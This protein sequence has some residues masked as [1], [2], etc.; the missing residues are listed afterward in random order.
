M[1]RKSRHSDVKIT[2]LA[3]GKHPAWPDFIDDGAQ[4]GAAVVA[5]RDALWTRGLQR[6][7]QLGAFNTLAE[8]SRVRFSHDALIVTSDGT[9]VAR[10]WPGVDARGASGWPMIAV[11]HAEPVDPSWLCEVAPSR[12][13]AVQEMSGQ[14]RNRQLV[15]LSL[16]EAARQLEDTLA[17]V[18]GVPRASVSDGALLAQADAVKIAAGLEAAREQLT[19]DAR[20]EVG[21]VLRLPRV[22]SPAAPLENARVWAAALRSQ[23][24]AGLALVALE[25][26]ESD[27]VD[28]I[29]GHGKS[30]RWGAVRDASVKDSLAGRSAP[31]DASLAHVKQLK[32]TLG[33]RTR[34]AGTAPETMKPSRR[35]VAL[36]TA[37]GAL[38]ATTIVAAVLMRNTTPGGSQ[39]AGVWADARPGAKARVS[40]TAG[41]SREQAAET[42][43]AAMVEHALAAAEREGAA[44]GAT[45]P[46]DVARRARDVMARGA[47]DE[48]EAREALRLVEAWRSELAGRVLAEVRAKQQV[49][50]ELDEAQ[51][52][53]ADAWRARL[54]TI[55]PREG[56]A[57]ARA[58]MTREE[59]GLL[60]ALDALG[61][62]KP[63]AALVKDA[64][65]LASAIDAA[66]RDAAG[67]LAA[68]LR[69]GADT[70]A[71]RER[72]STLRRAVATLRDDARDEL[73]PLQRVPVL[74]ATARDALARGE[75]WETLAPTHAALATAASDASVRAV[76]GDELRRLEAVRE[77]NQLPREQVAEAMRR[78]AADTTGKRIAE[79]MQGWRRLAREGDVTQ[80]AEIYSE[81]V[82]PAAGYVPDAGARA[83]LEREAG[84]LAREAWLAAQRDALEDDRVL[85]L[86]ELAAKLDA[87]DAGEAPAWLRAKARL[88]AARLRRAIAANAGDDA[89]LEH[90]RELSRHVRAAGEALET[91]PDAKRLR[92]LDAL[93]REA[94]AQREG[95]RMWLGVKGPGTLGWT[96]R[97]DG[98]GTVTFTSPTGTRAAFA[99]QVDAKTQ[100]VTYIARGECSVAVV[101]DALRDETSRATVAGLLWKFDE[102]ADPRTGPRTWTWRGGTIVPTRE[103]HARVQGSEV[104]LAPGLSA[105]AP[106]AS[107]PMNYVSARAAEAI[108]AA[109]RCRLLTRE[110]WEATTA[111]AAGQAANEQNTMDMQVVEQ[112]GFA[113]RTGVRAARPEADTGWADASGAMDAPP[114]DGALWLWAAERGTETARFANMWGNVAEWVSTPAGPVIIGV[115]ALSVHDGRAV[116]PASS[117]AL[118]GFADVGFRLAFDVEP[119]LPTTDALTQLRAKGRE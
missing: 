91:W 81:V 31:S 110:E 104:L 22:V 14:T 98:D 11:A 44:Q 50:G 64:P 4:H 66:R 105:G 53:V 58:R 33:T 45:M 106:D 103:W 88:E 3:L 96:L 108:A 19:P 28:V 7:C 15:G 65:M 49:A 34:G 94:I 95:T 60:A 74:Q 52:V 46:D 117:D 99:R 27:C 82:K 51:R 71:V 80:A 29:I 77:V 12:L 40:G 21:A 24:E 42:V 63:G 97:D 38:V 115:S 76:V 78:A 116:T 114:S 43:T 30:D 9:C 61:E 47:A 92:A 75:N 23:M 109:L 86:G 2:V 89:L 93:A 16:G 90:A 67:E 101:M 5:A 26:D 111:V 54:M 1:A 20:G 112:A 10:L 69:D 13:R 8:E 56:M 39:P 59:D 25:R 68:L 72:A 18:V 35:S 107:M 32:Q 79:I 73:P 48:A 57:A 37:G 83:R 119:D 87:Q 113:M 17:L 70:S 102:A 85:A 100:R 84:A 118:R 55:N 36:L 41:D 6:A 62:T